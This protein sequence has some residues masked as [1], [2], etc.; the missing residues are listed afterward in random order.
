M[1]KFLS[2]P[3]L[4]SAAV[5]GFIILTLDLAFDLLTTD[6]TRFLEFHLGL[7]VFT[8]VFLYF[9]LGRQFIA[10]EKAEVER[11]VS[12]Q[13]LANLLNTAA[14]AIIATDHNLT[15]VVYNQ[16]AE[17]I[18]GYSAHEAIGSAVT[19]LLPPR[20]ATDRLDYFQKLLNPGSGQTTQKKQIEWIAHRKNGTEFPAEV[21]VSTIVRDG[22]PSITL[23][24][25]DI[26]IR[27]QAEEALRWVHEDLEQRIQER[28]ATLEQTNVALQQQI[29]ERKRV[30][31]ERERLL[32]QVEQER[33]RA[34]ALAIEAKQ[35]A[36]ELDAVFAAM[37]DGVIVFDTA[38]VAHKANP[39]AILVAGFNMVGTHHNV[40]AERL[41]LRY[42]D[43]NPVAPQDLPVQRVL[44]GQ[45][46]AGERY[47]VS[48]ANGA[49]RTVLIAAAPI[50]HS[51][52]V[53]GIVLVVHDITQHENLQEDL[54]KALTET[55]ERQVEIAGLLTGARAVLEHHDFE[56]VA[57][58]IFLICSNLVGAGGG[59]IALLGDDDKTSHQ[60]VFE[61]ALNRHSFA[62]FQSSPL[63]A[64]LTQQAYLTGRPVFYNYLEHHENE[65]LAATD[66]QW[67]ILLTPLVVKGI[68]VGVLAL[69]NKPL[70]FSENDGRM[71]TAFGE[72]VAIS[73]LNTRTMRSLENSEAR[74]RSV[75]QAANE[76]IIAIDDRGQIVFWNPAATT[77]FGYSAAEVTGQNMTL[78]IPDSLK[79]FHVSALSQSVK[80]KT[81]NLVRSTIE[82]SGRRKNGE[83]F[84][85]QLSISSWNMQGEV[86]FTGIIQDITARKQAEAALEKARLELEVRV[87]ERTQQLAN[88]NKE[89]WAE[90]EERE[91]VEQRLRLRT[92][93]LQAAANGVIITD[94]Q[95]IVR[96]ANPA[97]TTMTGYEVEEI[98]GQN[99]R[100]LK[101]NQ[102]PPEFYD[103]LWQ[104]ILAGQVWSG[105]LVNRRKDGSLYTE[106]Q[107]ITPVLDKNRNIT[108]FIAIKQD[109][110][111][112]VQ[113]YQLLEQRVQERTQ[114]LST[115]LEISGNLALTLELEPRLQLVLDSLKAVVDYSCAT[116]YSLR[117]NVLVVLASRKSLPLTGGEQFPL[118]LEITP[119]WQK[120][121]QE[122]QPVIIADTRAEPVVA[123]IFDSTMDSLMSKDCQQV[124]SWLGIPLSIKDRTIGVLEIRHNRP[125]YYTPQQIKL[126]Q[127][128]ANQVAVTIENHRLYEQAQELATMQ[129]RQRLSRDL[130]DAVSQ[131]LFSASLAAEVLPIL[132]KNRPDQGELCLAEL[133]TLTKGALAEMRTL[134]LELRPSALT[135]SKLDELLQQLVT[136]MVSRTR[137]PIQLDITPLPVLPS[138]V[139]VTLYRIA[140]EALNNIVK[141]A[142]AD[143]V[144]VK[145]T[146]APLN[147]A[148][149]NVSPAYRVELT[150]RDNGLGFDLAGIP[151]GHL[152]L[153]IMQERAQAIGATLKV[154][155]QIGR[156]TEV[157]VVWPQTD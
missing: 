140:Q 89:L 93:A 10:R 22:K 34:E 122:Q 100:F 134:L 120:V 81:S 111:E 63:I 59:Y 142:Q 148:A 145:L 55:R 18:F 129:E 27:K 137:I 35:R 130:H 97:I 25:R 101:S 24:L 102:Q 79:H 67:N 2:R 126:T 41:R 73:L 107:T 7:I 83:E 82:L 54:R 29:N 110:T 53:A 156:G 31:Q 125:I 16:A 17:R 77:I 4:I 48:G 128:F 20:L 85:L 90:I 124:R 133:Q 72:L 98:I 139:Q 50:A 65:K 114:E 108:H 9:V 23:I 153:G 8:V 14:D 36:D 42:R 56:N 71:T 32:A 39:S 44:N 115:L 47:T 21:S 121:I 86:F 70:G 37:S 84:P 46:V 117:E 15:I 5:T 40:L 155:S 157:G 99:M 132:W 64:E 152:G 151:A 118:L 57:R 38:G 136:A 49:S 87:R 43:G 144:R 75:V 74:F 76:A 105:E 33:E 112:R 104:T 146:H 131:T 88:T 30:E 58:K 109:I 106:G 78:M 51:S 149:D 154:T 26:S 3:A 69:I 62:T 60:I 61:D 13:Q 123:R 28:T 116:V 1:G 12:E 138:D 80:D 147:P 119:I 96:W 103:R 113:A 143:D 11:H 127:A 6:H 19:L 94:Q 92:T 150:V 45:P 141:H 135:D 91:K 52:A 95:G 66:D 68:A